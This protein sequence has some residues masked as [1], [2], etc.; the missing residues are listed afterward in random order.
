MFFPIG[1][2]NTEFIF[3]RAQVPEPILNIANNLI[4][5][6]C[7]CD[8]LRFENVIGQFTTINN[9]LTLFNESVKVFYKKSS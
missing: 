3:L 8:N 7:D 4:K 6:W 5:K 9:N 2:I 1:K